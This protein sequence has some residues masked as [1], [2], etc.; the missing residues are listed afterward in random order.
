MFSVKNFKHTF[1]NKTSV[2]IMC[3]IE[4]RGEGNTKLEFKTQNNCDFMYND[5]YATVIN[6]TTKKVNFDMNIKFE[7]TTYFVLMFIDDKNTPYH[8]ELKSMRL[9][10]N[11]QVVQKSNF[12]IE[13]STLTLYL[14]E[15]TCRNSVNGYYH[16]YVVECLDNFPIITET[17]GLIVYQIPE[18]RNDT[19]FIVKLISLK[20]KVRGSK[21]LIIPKTRDLLPLPT[22]QVKL[23]ANTYN[24]SWFHPNDQI[25]SFIVYWCIK[26]KDDNK[27][28]DGSIKSKTFLKLDVSTYSILS[29]LKDLK[30]GVAANSEHSTSGIKFVN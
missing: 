15:E 24:V 12:H 25:T 19:E 5:E 18:R 9:P 26:N 8:F 22:V 23:T 10:F 30:V 20:G 3:D 7:L 4:Y 13:N 17:K 29:N 21:K 6:S 27:L 11:E 1:I 16:Q 28:C 14:Q 2:R